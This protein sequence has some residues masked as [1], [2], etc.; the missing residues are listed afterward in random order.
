MSRQTSDTVACYYCGNRLDAAM[1][2]RLDACPQCG[3]YLHVCRMCVYYDPAETSSQCTED[4]AEKVHDKQAAN[5][6]DYFS[7]SANAFD[8]AEISADARARTQLTALFDGNDSQANGQ[9]PSEAD[10]LLKDAEAL[11]KK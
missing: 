1:P 11:F 4:D 2:G 9:Q 8:V 6:C 10:D 5:F 3:K 7:L